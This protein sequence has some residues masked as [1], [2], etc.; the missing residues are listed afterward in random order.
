MLAS[1]QNSI[2]PA[3]QR[4]NLSR[5]DA[6]LSDQQRKSI[7]DHFAKLRKTQGTTK[8]GPGMEPLIV[9][10]VARIIDAIPDGD[11]CGALD[12]SLFIFSVST[13]ARAISSGFE[14]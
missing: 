3:L 1:L 12:A 14:T 10:D 4:L 8:E 13:G 2:Y 9:A 5:A 7:N 6:E 11:P